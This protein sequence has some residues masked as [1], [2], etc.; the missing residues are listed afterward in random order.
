MKKKSVLFAPLLLCFSFLL[1]C[2]ELGNGKEIPPCTCVPLIFQENSQPINPDTTFVL[3]TCGIKLKRS[4]CDST[5]YLNWRQNEF[6]KS[7][8][9]AK[10][11]FRLDFDFPAIKLPKYPK[12]SNIYV[13]WR[14]IDTIYFSVREVFKK[15][16]NDYGF[17]K[18]WKAAPHID[19]GKGSQ[20][21]WIEFDNWVV[22]PYIEYAINSNIQNANCEFYGGPDYGSTEFIEKKD[23]YA[24]IISEHSGY[25]TISRNCNYI[26]FPDE[27]LYVFD[28]IGNCLKIQTLNVN[29]SIID[30]SNL[31]PG[32][33]F[34]KVGNIIK[35]ITITN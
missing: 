25:L 22:I 6:V 7:R 16:E 3:D 11:M 34:I 2:S 9:L 8:M 30:I 27:K 5:F 1:L 20:L 33:Y 17:F 32:L 31:S 24:I 26:I 35:H 21:F 19:T 12:D 10:N 29:Q 23:D 18:F 13:S 28:I 4:T 14:D 15:I